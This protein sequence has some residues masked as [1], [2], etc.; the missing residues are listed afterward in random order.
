[1]V[2]GEQGPKEAGGNALLDANPWGKA[3]VMAGV[4]LLG[5]GERLSAVGN[6]MVMERDWVCFIQRLFYIYH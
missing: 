3:A 2:Q 4:M 1:M 5:I 6:I